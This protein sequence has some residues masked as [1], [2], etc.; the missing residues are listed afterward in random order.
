MI[1]IVRVVRGVVVT[2][3]CSIVRVIMCIY[4][5]PLLCVIM[6]IQYVYYVNLTITRLMYQ[7]HRQKMKIQNYIKDMNK[8][9]IDFIN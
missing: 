8:K 9:K 4:S 5:A 3:T 2:I 7:Y 1:M 6:C